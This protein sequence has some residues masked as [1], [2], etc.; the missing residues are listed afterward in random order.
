MNKFKLTVFAL[1][2]YGPTA[3]SQC[4]PGIPGAGN[5]GCIPPTAPGSPYGQPE[6]AGASP[7][8]AP[9]API[10]GDRWGAIAIDYNNGAA[11]G[12]N[13]NA[14]K[15]DATQLATE[16]CMHAGGIHCEIAV[17][18]VNQCAAIAQKSGRGLLY[19][20]TAANTAADEAATRAIAICGDIAEC[21]IVSS[22][23]SYAVRVR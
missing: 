6:S 22:L 5:P 13:K 8:F 19:P 23:C 11:G 17:S 9:P 1:L 7:A 10:W 14:T 12:A 2:I 4:A 18:F 15:S 3:W 21:K 16:R 20:A